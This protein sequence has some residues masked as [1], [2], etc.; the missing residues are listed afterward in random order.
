M[1]QIKGQPY[2]LK[3]HPFVVAQ[4]HPCVTPNIEEFTRI[5][6]NNKINSKFEQV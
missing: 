1:K 4:L 3:P 5:S 6:S 2:T